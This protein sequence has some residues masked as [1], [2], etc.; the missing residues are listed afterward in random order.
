[1]RWIDTDKNTPKDGPTEECKSSMLLNRYHHLS[2][3]I[4]QND[5]QMYQCRP[6]LR[7]P[8]RYAVAPT[9]IPEYI[10]TCAR[11]LCHQGDGICVQSLL[12]PP[13]DEQRYILTSLHQLAMQTD[14]EGLQGFFIKLLIHHDTDSITRLLEAAMNY[15]QAMD[16]I[17]SIAAYTES[18]PIHLVSVPYLSA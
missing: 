16:L 11:Y 18:L 10:E 15:N 4:V 8:R 14:I 17:R 2:T 1:M 12:V 7:C 5:T 3:S 6:Y 9:A 13:L